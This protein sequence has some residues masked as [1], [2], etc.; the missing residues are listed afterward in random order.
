[1]QRKIFDFLRGFVILIMFYIT[2]FCIVKALH[3]MLPPAILGLML[4]AAALISGIIKE[5][6]I[7]SA[8]NFLIKYMGLFIVPFMGALILYKSIL[9]KNWF[10]I[11]FVI[12]ITTTLLIVTIGLFVEHGLRFLELHK[13]RKSR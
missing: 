2:S 8:S 13:I 7:N 10:V 6:W 5:E 12:F 4:F 9:I 11:L 3:L 1:M